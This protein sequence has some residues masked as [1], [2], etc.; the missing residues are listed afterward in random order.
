MIKPAIKIYLQGTGINLKA[1][2]YE[3][4]IH[5]GTVS[6]DFQLS[7]FFSSINLI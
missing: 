6:R 5:E 7:V 4:K 1:Q 3:I 2:F